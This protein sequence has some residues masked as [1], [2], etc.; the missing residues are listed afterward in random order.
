MADVKVECGTIDPEYKGVA[1][2][3]LEAVFLQTEEEAEKYGAIMKEIME[4]G[5]QAEATGNFV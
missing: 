5:I 4:S 1:N 3:T 2:P